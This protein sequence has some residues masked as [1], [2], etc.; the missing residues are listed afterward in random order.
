MKTSNQMSSTQVVAHNIELLYF[1]RNKSDNIAQYKDICNLSLRFI[2]LESN[3]MK[4]VVP[5]HLLIK[6]ICV[7]TSVTTSLQY[8]CVTSAERVLHRIARNWCLTV[9]VPIRA[10]SQKS[11]FSCP[12]RKFPAARANKS[13]VAMCSRNCRNQLQYL[14]EL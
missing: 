14:D 3:K 13:M 12:P 7:H 11:A 2:S 8:T 9:N 4:R 10:A 6:H 1:L 5:A